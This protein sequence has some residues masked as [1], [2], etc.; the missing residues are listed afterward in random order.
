MNFVFIPLLVSWNF[1]WFTL[2]DLSFPVLKNLIS[3]NFTHVAPLFGVDKKKLFFTF[4][5]PLN[6]IILISSVDFY[7]INDEGWQNGRAN[8]P[9]I[10]IQGSIK[11]PAKT[12]RNVNIR[13]T[14]KQNKKFGWFFSTSNFLARL[15]RSTKY[16]LEVK[17]R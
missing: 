13:T 14:D 7:N 4:F 2:N 12:V 9:W 8:G 6:F 16:R 11:F 10:L 5:D 3:R 1:V 17:K 15:N